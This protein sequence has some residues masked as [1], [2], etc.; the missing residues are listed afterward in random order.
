[1]RMLGVAL[2][3]YRTPLLATV[4][5]VTVLSLVKAIPCVGGILSLVIGCVGLGA[6]VLALLYA[7]RSARL[8]R[9]RR[10]RDLISL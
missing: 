4:L 3:E 9:W 8:A 7:R 2:P 10:R 1:S 5:G 6:S